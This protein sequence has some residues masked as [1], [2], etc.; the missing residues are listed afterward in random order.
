MNKLTSATIV[1]LVIVLY[2]LFEQRNALQNKSTALSVWQD[3]V[4][5]YKNQQGELI[6]QKQIA[7][8]TIRDL[9]EIGHQLGIDRDKLSDQVG[10]LRN[11]NAHYKGEIKSMG[12]GAT[13]TIDTVIQVIESIGD[14]VKVVAQSVD[15]TNRYLSI[16]GIFIPSFNK[17][18]FNYNYI[19][20]LEIV[21]Y[22]RKIKKGLFAPKQLVVDFKLSDPNASVV[23]LKALQ[24]VREKKWYQ[25]TGFKIG[26][27]MVGGIL[28]T[29]QFNK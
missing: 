8:V 1:L 17:W 24:I 4:S 23:D 26:L 29:N 2:S 13:V 14:T 9:K 27:G 19:V 11:L 25:T 22:D 20:D 21:S 16:D 28:L 15:W 6:A 3:S 7:E 12:K 5:Y 18:E 10:S